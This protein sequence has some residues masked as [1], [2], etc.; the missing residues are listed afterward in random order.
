LEIHFGLL[1]IK[2]TLYYND[3]ELDEIQ[4]NTIDLLILV[5]NFVQKDLC[6][7]ITKRSLS[8]LK[9]ISQSEPLLFIKNFGV[10]TLL[11]SHL[12]R[13]SEYFTKIIQIFSNVCTNIEVN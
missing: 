1:G 6:P 3:L 13:N 5:L 8:I 12:T 9:D 4:K 10:Q 7:E 11:N 2:N